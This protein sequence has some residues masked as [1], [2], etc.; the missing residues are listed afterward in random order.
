MM[1][2]VLLFPDMLKDGDKSLSTMRVA[3]FMIVSV[4]S[5]LCIK[6]FWDAGIQKLDGSWAA[7]IIAALGGKAIQSLG[8][9]NV[10]GS[11]GNQNPLT[12]NPLFNGQAP[13]ID[14]PVS[15]NG[16]TRAPKT[17]PA[18]LLPKPAKK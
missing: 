15:S 17:R 1:G 18:H 10:F 7:V 3:V 2:I 16:V 11:A 9:N 14:L 8:E 4:F 13:P 6:S 5:I 12:E